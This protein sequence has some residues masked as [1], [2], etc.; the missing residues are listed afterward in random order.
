ML[1]WK[2]KYGV[3]SQQLNG[4]RPDFSKCAEEIVS[5]KGYGPASYQC[6]KKN[7]H[8]PDGAYCACH[9]KQFNA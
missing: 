5:S 8:G 6:K 2:R 3:W 1:H 9:A 7:G 4:V